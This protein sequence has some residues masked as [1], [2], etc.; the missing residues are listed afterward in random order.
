MTHEETLACHN[1]SV[2]SETQLQRI[3]C[4]A[5]CTFES[6]DTELCIEIND[7]TLPLKACIL[8]WWNALIECYIILQL[9][10]ILYFMPYNITIIIIFRPSFGHLHILNICIS[11][12]ANG[13]H[14]FSWPIKFINKA[15]TT[16]SSNLLHAEASSK[17]SFIKY[18]VKFLMDHAK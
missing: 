9:S 17:V 10:F 12:L 11:L 4:S 16:F 8:C 6:K 7:G 13:V 3:Q 15:A 14:F 1:C 5:K 18:H 2:K